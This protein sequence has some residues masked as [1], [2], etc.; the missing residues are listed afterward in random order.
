MQLR[1]IC[2][3]VLL[4]LLALISAA[5]VD[6]RQIRISKAYA[7]PAEPPFATQVDAAGDVWHTNTLVAITHANLIYNIPLTSPGD[8]EIIFDDSSTYNILSEMTAL[9]PD[10]F[11][12]KTLRWEMGNAGG[13]VKY[14]DVVMKAAPG[15]TPTIDYS[16]LPNNPQIGGRNAIQILHVFPDTRRFTFEGIRF[17]NRDINESPNGSSAAIRLGGNGTIILKNCVS[18]SVSPIV[19][20]GKWDDSESP[21]FVDDVPEIDRCAFTILKGNNNRIIA[22][23]WNLESDG[24]LNIVDSTFVVEAESPD[25]I[26][27][28]TTAVIFEA[29]PGGLRPDATYAT[30]NTLIVGATDLINMQG[31]YDATK[32]SYDY[33]IDFPAIAGK[34]AGTGNQTADPL[35]LINYPFYTIDFENSPATDAGA[36][37]VTIGYAKQVPV[38]AARNFTLYE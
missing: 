20:L 31:G 37:G 10:Y 5:P 28:T 29:A 17:I 4:G 3:L 38:S 34:V 8:L 2:S 30:S 6:A 15:M 21:N 27:T 9:E 25:L 11:F 19:W 7:T 26:T 32:L 36:G 16:G 1:F 13:T 24:R 35:L 22:P 23:I 18:E 33:N 14:P 12:Q